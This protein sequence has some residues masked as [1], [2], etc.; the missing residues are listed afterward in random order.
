[1][2]V[3]KIYHIKCRI[4]RVLKN[5]CDYEKTENGLLITSH[6]CQHQTAEYEFKFKKK[7]MNSNVKN[8]A[9]HVIQ[10]FRKG[11]VTAEQAHEIGLET[12]KIFLNNEYE[13]IIA[14]HTDKQNIINHVLINSVNYKTGKSFST[15]HDRKY[16]PAWKK[17]KEIS[18]Q[19]CTERNLSI[20]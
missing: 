4:D 16:S 12:M 15:Q 3:T 13:F 7:S 18:D 20:I 17:I 19:I 8:I 6:K 10:S 1:M 14:T 11:E 9:F 2:A 5:I